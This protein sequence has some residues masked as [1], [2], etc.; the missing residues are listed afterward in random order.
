[1]C[2]CLGMIACVG[3]CVSLR[4]VWEYHPLSL[5]ILIL[6]QAL[7][8]TLVIALSVRL[9]VQGPRIY[10]SVPF[11]PRVMDVYYLGCWGPEP[12]SSR[13]HSQCLTH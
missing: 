2:V 10:L 11:N 13:L 6:K 3:T 5:T 1:M 12:R 7:S 8:R 9:A 4:L